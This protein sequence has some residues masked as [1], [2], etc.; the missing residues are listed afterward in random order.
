MI[1][2][3]SSDGYQV[4]SINK[5]GKEYLLADT[6]R[7]EDD[8]DKLISNLSDLKFDSLIIVFGVDTGEYLNELDKHLCSQN[9]VLIFEPNEEIFNESKKIE[10]E[11]KVSIVLYDKEN[12]EG[13]LA[14]I[15]N[16][17]NFDNLYVH[18]FGNYKEIYSSEYEFLI[19]K[20]SSLYIDMS[21]NMYLAYRC[22][23]SFMKNTIS[24]LKYINSSSTLNSY[25]NINKNIPAIIVSAGPSLEKNI[26]HMKKNIDKVRKCFVIA[27]NRTFSAL[28]KNGITPDVVVCID[29]SEAMYDMMKDNLNSDVPIVYYEYTNRKLIDNYKG[30]K[31]FMSTVLSRVIKELSD[32]IALSQGGSVAHACISLGNILGCNPMILAGQDLAYTFEKHHSDNAVFDVDKLINCS[33]DILVE[34]VFGNKVSTTL[35]LNL[36]KK[37]IEY[38]IEEY[39]KERNIEFINVS[40]GADI[41]GA[42]HRELNEVLNKIKFF[43]K[44]KRSIVPIHDI[45]FDDKIILKNILEFIEKYIEKSKQGMEQCTILKNLKESKSLV[46]TSEEDIDFQRFLFVFDIVNTFEKSLE[47]SYLGGYFTKF[48]YSIKRE[49]FSMLASDYEMLTSDIKYQGSVFLN[50][51]IKMNEMLN[52]A[53]T[54]ILEEIQ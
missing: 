9:K 19:E 4:F 34:D 33:A 42:P 7:C 17:D 46:S 18:A 54:T 3:K 26:Q 1:K 45:E 16:I 20:I 27:N 50:Y 30:E 6:N 23:E 25:V 8:I 39:K 13:V 35:T 21:A 38:N 51:F 36:F 43:R 52:D 32:N 10:L 31:I 40:Y 22:D 37:R 12:A 29:P 48:M 41:K 24:N 44:K 28:I 15:I 11:D 5:D 47:W 49:N 53:K 2:K 14:T